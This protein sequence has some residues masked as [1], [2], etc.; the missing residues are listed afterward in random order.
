MAP[1]RVN[2]DGYL[3]YVAKQ[4]RREP[5]DVASMRRLTGAMALRLWV[6][7]IV[8][9]IMAGLFLISRL[10]TFLGGTMVTIAG[11]ALPIAL[12][13]SICWVLRRP[14][15]SIPRILLWL[16]VIGLVGGIIGLII[17]QGTAWL[18]IVA[19]LGVWLLLVGIV[20]ALLVG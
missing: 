15:Q 9:A 1:K 13:T 10:P 2:D 14:A 5:L 3:A 20:A 18:M 6:V 4:K 8:C 16:G 12:V 17:W 7:V 19:A 11:L